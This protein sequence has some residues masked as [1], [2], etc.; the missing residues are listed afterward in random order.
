MSG[1]GCEIEIK[2][3]EQKGVLI[4]LLVI[5]VFMFVFEVSLG[6]YAQSTGLIADSFDMHRRCH[7]L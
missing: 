5:N 2:D 4:S 7:R 3:K 1:C 6:W